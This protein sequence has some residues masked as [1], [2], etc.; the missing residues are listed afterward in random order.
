MNRESKRT[1]GKVAFM[2]LAFYV[3]FGLSCF[4]SKA[5]S[6]RTAVENNYLLA[7]LAMII[8][9]ALSVAIVSMCVKFIS[10]LHH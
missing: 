6:L 1:L 4:L 9:F 2:A 5:Q 7:L 10:T 3:A 8:I